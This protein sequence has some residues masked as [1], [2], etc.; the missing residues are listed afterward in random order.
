M[1]RTIVLSSAF[2]MTL[3]M[4]LGVPAT[5]NASSNGT[6][7]W[8]HSQRV[9]V[10]GIPAAAEALSPSMVGPARDDDSD[11]LTRNTGECN[12]GCIDN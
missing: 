2:V 10:H 11:G 4:T 7:R 5:S 8:T 9:H 3:A 12:R 6:Q 1:K